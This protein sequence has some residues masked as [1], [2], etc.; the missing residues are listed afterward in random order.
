MMSRTKTGEI[1]FA[2]LAI[3]VIA[4]LTSCSA[5]KKNSTVFDEQSPALESAPTS[6]I[7]ALQSD[8]SF[9]S[10]VDAALQGIWLIET[11]DIIQKI[12]FEKGDYTS[13][14]IANRGEFVDIGSYTLYEKTIDT[15]H[16]NSDGSTVTGHISYEYEEGNLKLI[17]T[18]GSYI[19]KIS[20]DNSLTWGDDAIVCDAKQSRPNNEKESLSKD[21]NCNDPPLY[22]GTTTTGEANALRT[23]K[24][25]LAFTSFSYKGLIEQLEYEGFSHDEARYAADHCGADWFEQAVFK[26]ADYLDLMAF[27]RT[28]LIEQLEFEGF[29]YEQAV[30][31]V[32]HNG[33]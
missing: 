22:T 20:N 10:Q 1:W 28:S 27:S 25:Y 17:A 5:G 21:S 16:L 33:Y 12:S 13:L 9:L 30:Y 4:S 23:S 26:A 18:D 31:G 2:L 32:E 15:T 8:E 24:D 14:L 6:T 3:F 29:T 11:G 19:V 7:K